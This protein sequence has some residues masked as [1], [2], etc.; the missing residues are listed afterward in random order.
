M[1]PKGPLMIEHRRI[2]RM[3]SLIANEVKRIGETKVV[4]QSFIDTA[5]DFIRTYAD[6]THHGKEEEI[7]FRDL[8]KKKLSVADDTVMNELIQEHKEGRATTVALVTAAEAY[9]KGNTE[10]LSSIT[11]NL[12]KFVDFY[13]RHIRKEDTLFFPSAMTYLSE[14]EQQSMLAEFREFDRKMIHAKYQSVLE[15]LKR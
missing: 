1:Q 15:S 8:S 10:A 14:T 6:R 4:N 13:P 2:E 9:Q 5:V 12:E 7:L 11:R 3:I